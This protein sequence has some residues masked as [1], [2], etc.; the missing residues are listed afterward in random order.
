[1]DIELSRFRVRWGRMA[2]VEQWLEFLNGN[3]P[4]VLQT[5]EGENMLVE[6]IFHEHLDGADFLYW[7]SIQGQGGIDVQESEH[8][9]DK[10]HLEYWRECIDREYPSVDLK[11]RA[12][13][14][15]EAIRNQLES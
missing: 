7:F 14:I 13:M 5:L 8:W 9:V 3:M 1:M 10:K 2:V 11:P 12:A 4:A 6:T 15:T